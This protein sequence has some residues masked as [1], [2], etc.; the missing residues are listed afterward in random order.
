MLPEI[1]KQLNQTQLDALE[2]LPV[3]KRKKDVKKKID[4]NSS[5]DGDIEDSDSDDD[6]IPELVGQNF[7]SVSKQD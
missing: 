7:E 2:N 3:D 5:E 1:L 4:G 6:D